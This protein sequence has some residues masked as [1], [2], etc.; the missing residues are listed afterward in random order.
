[1]RG[2]VHLRERSLACTVAAYMYVCVCMSS[3]V[4]VRELH[5]LGAYDVLP[6]HLVVWLQFQRDLIVRNRPVR[7]PCH[8]RRRPI[9][10]ERMRC[11]MIRL[12][13][14]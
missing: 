2:H 10:A 14:S 9:A 13:R 11:G 1:M 7:P 6:H 4:H 12:G 5:V 3:F 8:A